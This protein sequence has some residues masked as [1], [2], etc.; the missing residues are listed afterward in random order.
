MPVTLFRG[1][2]PEISSKITS[3]QIDLLRR[4]GEVCNPPSR[5]RADVMSATRLS[6]TE[7][8][9]RGGF[10]NP[11]LFRRGIKSGWSYWTT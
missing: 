8:Y 1:A 7:W 2:K 5:Q 4:R 6:K 9:R 10:S 3:I 11:L